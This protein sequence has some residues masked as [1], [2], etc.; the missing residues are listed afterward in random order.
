[1]GNIVPGQICHGPKGVFCRLATTS[2]SLVKLSKNDWKMWV[3]K[4]NFLGRQLGIPSSRNPEIYSQYTSSNLWTLRGAAG[5]AW[6]LGLGDAF[7]IALIGGLVRVVRV[8][9]EQR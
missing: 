5:V 6:V 4:S 2:M 3:E 1:M 9:G 8:R 7:S